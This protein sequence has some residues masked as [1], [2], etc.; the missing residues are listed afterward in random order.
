MVQ[1]IL[2]LRNI[3][4]IHT[5]PKGI[6]QKVNVISQLELEIV[7]SNVS[8]ARQLLR[9]ETLSLYCFKSSYEILMI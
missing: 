3:N 7:Y 8:P 5:F 1:F 4:G 9:H 6:D 2:Q